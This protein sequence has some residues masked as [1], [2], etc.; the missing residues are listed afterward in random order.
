M[1]DA[2]RVGRFHRDRPRPIIVRF[3]NLETKLQV[4]RS[5]G[6]LYGAACPPELQGLRVY[7]DLSPGQLDWKRKLR[8]SYEQ[9]LGL[10]IRVVFRRGY[11]LF[12]LLG[13]TWTEFFPSSV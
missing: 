1:T 8:G 12:A 5:K 11:R 4:L 13:G 3:A 2:Y 10:G 7:H 6:V 9:L